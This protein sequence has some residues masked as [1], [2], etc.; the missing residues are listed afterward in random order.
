MD[1]KTPRYFWRHSKRNYV[2]SLKYY[3]TFLESQKRLHKGAPIF[4]KRANYLFLTNSQKMCLEKIQNAIKLSRS[5]PVYMRLAGNPGT[6]KTFMLSIFSDQ[7]KKAGLKYCV[8]TYTGKNACNLNGMTI[9]RLLGWY[10]CKKKFSNTYQYAVYSCYG[11][12]N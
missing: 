2:K 6:G 4:H 3:A 8:A 1:P 5:Q 12:A 10:D 7:V 9:H 11:T